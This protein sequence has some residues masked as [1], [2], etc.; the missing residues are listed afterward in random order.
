[1][2]LVAGVYVRVIVENS[3]KFFWFTVYMHDLNVLEAFPTQEVLHRQSSTIHS[4][5]NGHNAIQKTS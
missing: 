2:Q 4:R 3:G 1:M 5:N